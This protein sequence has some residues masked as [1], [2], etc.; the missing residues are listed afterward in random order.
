MLSTAH[1]AEEAEQPT[2]SSTSVRPTDIN[3][4]PIIWHGNPAHLDLEGILY[5]LGKYVTRNGTFVP[6]F[7]HCAVL[8]PNGKMATDSI[9]ASKFLTG[10]AESPI[11]YDFNNPCPPT[12]QRITEFDALAQRSRPATPDFV[13]IQILPN[14][15]NIIVSPWVIKNADRKL[16]GII[17]LIVSDADKRSRL[18]DLSNGLG[19]VLIGLLRAESLTATQKDKVLVTEERNAHVNAGVRGELNLNSFN[20]F[21]RQFHHLQNYVPLAARSS[22]DTIIQMLHSIIFKDSGVNTVFEIKLANSPNMDLDLTVSTV[23]EVLR[24]RMVSLEIDGIHSPTGRTTNSAL[25]AVQSAARTIDKYETIRQ[26]NGGLSDVQ[27]AALGEAKFVVAGPDPKKN[28]R[29]DKKKKEWSKKQKTGDKIKTAGSKVDVPRNSEGRVIAWIKG[30]PP[31]NCGE[32]HLFRDC[33]TRGAKPNTAALAASGCF[34]CDPDVLGPGVVLSGFNF[35]GQCDEER[36]HEVHEAMVFTNATESIVVDELGQRDAPLTYS[37]SLS[38]ETQVRR[39]VFSSTRSRSSVNISHW[40]VSEGEHAGVYYG[41]WDD[42]SALVADRSTGVAKEFQNE[43]DALEHARLTIELAG[44]SLSDHRHPIVT[45]HVPTGDQMHIASGAD[46]SS[47]A[48]ILDTTPAQVHVPL[49]SAEVRPLV[50]AL[51]VAPKAT[52]TSPGVVTTSHPASHDILRDNNTVF[53]NTTCS[54]STSPGVVTISRITVTFSGPFSKEL[55]FP[56]SV[57]DFD[58]SRVA[59]KTSNNDGRSILATRVWPVF[60]VW[61]L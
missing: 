4:Q 14:E 7:T 42:V 34:G 43:I 48:L 39:R 53:L 57:S 54:R 2:P 20:I 29:P 45:T 9:Q 31:C 38:T 58:S 27:H 15:A 16:F 28:P 56:F 59:K 17:V 8:L 47:G 55:K 18:E 52:S 19:T 10:E 26:R 3:H 22:D 40:A 33:P 51:G 50:E 12:E 6:L 36:I 60:A 11:K 49:A 41:S 1:S 44:Y 25:S 35:D 23:R 30:M 24:S 46:S 37:W 21:L 13:R 32:N 61:R 5:E